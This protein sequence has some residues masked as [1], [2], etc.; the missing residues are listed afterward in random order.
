MAELTTQ[1]AELKGHLDAQAAVKPAPPV[2]VQ[3]VAASAAGA[4]GVGEIIAV[5]EFH[6]RELSAIAAEVLQ[7]GYGYDLDTVQMTW[8]RFAAGDRQAFFSALTGPGG[9]GLAVHLTNAAQDE[10]YGADFS[11]ALARLVDNGRRF[12]D[13]LGTLDGRRVVLDFYQNG[14]LGEFL[15]AAHNPA[16]AGGQEVP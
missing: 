8:N 4:T 9:D 1:V 14:P 6:T 15:S 16:A 10:D 13:L 11:K 2:T 5:A 3:P 7:L 12:L